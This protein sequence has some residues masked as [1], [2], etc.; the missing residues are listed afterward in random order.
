MNKAIL[1][2]AVI[3]GG[4]AMTVALVNAG[5]SS[6]KAETSVELPT[7]AP[8]PAAVPVPT[9]IASLPM[10]EP[11]AWNPRDGMPDREDRGQRTRRG[12]GGPGGQ[13]GEGIPAEWRERW[14]NMSE[15]DRARMRQRMER[16]RRDMEDRMLA[17][18]DKDGDGV[19]SDE[20]RAEMRETLRR[21]R[22]AEMRG[23]FE[24]AF[25]GPIDL[26]DAEMA[27][28]TRMYFE[29]YSDQFRELRRQGEEMRRQMMANGEPNEAQMREMRQSMEAAFGE[30]QRQMQQ[31]MM[32][33]YDLDGDGMLTDIER[34]QASQAIRDEVNT[35]ALMRRVDTNRDGVIDENEAMNFMSQFDSG[36]RGADLN[37]D[38]SLDAEDFQRFLQ[39]LGR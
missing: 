31:Q 13:M 15:E 3:L 27:M 9:P 6:S 2:G 17:R 20:E 33:Q 29:Q 24:E 32:S 22:A 12:P 25:G 26:S 35:W 19:L 28:A 4:V 18:F 36:G 34:S 10:S 37:R 11:Q 30:M 1:G 23:R 16:G 5:G 38:G 21:E 14:E 7:S 8:A 39:L